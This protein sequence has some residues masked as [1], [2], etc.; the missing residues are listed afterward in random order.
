MNQG[1]DHQRNNRVLDP[2]TWED[3][4]DELPDTMPRYIVLSFELKHKDGR[5]SYPL[6][7]V[8]YVPESAKIDLK[9]IYSSLS[10]A[11]FPKGHLTDM[12]FFTGAKPAFT[13]ATD[14]GAKVLDLQNIEDINYEYISGRLLGTA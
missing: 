7:F 11:R 14:L 1:F 8:Y 10:N 6:V 4:Q 3:L 13:Q 2:T 12:L 5:V 9:M